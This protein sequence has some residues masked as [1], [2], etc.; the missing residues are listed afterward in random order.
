M[1]VWRGGGGGP[2]LGLENSEMFSS[3]L[4]ELQDVLIWVGRTLGCRD[5]CLG[6]CLDLGWAGNSWLS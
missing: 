3:G 4:G 6:G 1:C 5:L 2:D